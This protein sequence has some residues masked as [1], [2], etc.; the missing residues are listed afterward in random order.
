[1]SDRRYWDARAG[2]DNGAGEV[3]GAVGLGPAGTGRRTGDG[4]PSGGLPSGGLTGKGPT[5][6]GG[7]RGRRARAGGRVLAGWSDVAEIL[8]GL[9]ALAS[10]VA[11]LV[12]VPVVL[13]AWRANPL[14]MAGQPYAGWDVVA[15]VSW[16]LWAWLVVCV[17]F[18]IAAQ[19]G[20]AAGRDRVAWPGGS[21]GGAGADERSVPGAPA[22]RPRGT[23]RGPSDGPAG[24]PAPAGAAARAADAAPGG[25]RPAPTPAPR[26]VRRGTARLVTTA[27]VVVAAMMSGRAALAA[28]APDPR[29]ATVATAT[30]GPADTTIPTNHDA[31]SPAG[32]DSPAA[33][34]AGG[35]A[36]GQA[37]ADDPNDPHG[38]DASGVAGSD[39]PPA[40]LVPTAE[41]HTVQRGES[42]W[43]IV[44]DGYPDAVLAQLPTAVDTV[45]AA[46]DGAADPAGH[47]LADPD[48]INPGMRLALPALDAAGHAVPAPAA[49]SPAAGGAPAPGGG[50]SAPSG[51]G[52]SAPPGGAPAGETPR[53]PAAAPT[54]P[55][56]G[57]QPPRAPAPQAT[58]P[59]SAP[60]A[61]GAPPPT[62]PAAGPSA[63]AGPPA[64]G[65]ATASASPAG[66]GAPSPGADGGR[67]SAGTGTPA[68]SRPGS[69]GTTGRAGPGR[70]APDVPKWQTE[71]WVVAGGLLGAA[72]VASVSSSRRRRREEEAA[73]TISVAGSDGP[74]PD[75]GPI[76]VE[77]LRPATPPPSPPTVAADADAV[78][79]HKVVRAA[80]LL[81]E[82]HLRS[83]NPDA[84][85]A[86][87]QR[88]LAV[89]PAHP[90]LFALRM[91]AYAAAGD[92]VAVT[93]EYGAFL[94]AEQASPSWTGE[95]NRGLES[96]YWSLRQELEPPVGS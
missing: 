7:E 89:H 56:G 19:R 30:A 84:A 4:K 68:N 83:G 64:P 55:S 3:A 54:A 1:M 92:H 48:L 93:G 37:D 49:G 43:S 40:A 17:G 36:T 75:G 78:R 72:S 66:P 57:T 80:L 46:N 18:E 90:D 34:G 47:R 28:T 96:L 63:A 8:R 58:A 39:G 73:D 27:G 74:Y 79:R 32:P 15:A 23:H 53:L 41:S 91:R 35:S 42:L 29:P 45:F 33:A 5:G 13:W 22:S 2:R 70:S 38:A 51:G 94:F 25:R 62:T 61:P 95:T 88:G 16:L 9:A 60:A 87:T 26:I 31:D 77:V 86:A 69:D 67:Q 82:Q 59:E 21:S 81:G 11:L 12:V 65:Q 20:R 50:A 44:E 52:T 10:L 71:T 14:P 85:L 24:G 6:S 76:S